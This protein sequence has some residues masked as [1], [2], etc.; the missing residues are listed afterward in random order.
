MVKGEHALITIKSRYA[1]RTFDKG[2]L[3]IPK[4]FEDKK[5]LIRKRRVV[6]DVQLIDFLPRVDV[7]RDR[8]IIKTVIKEGTGKKTPRQTDDIKGKFLN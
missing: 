5:E 6:Y 3:K 2:E 1:F 8:Q 4:G 7:N